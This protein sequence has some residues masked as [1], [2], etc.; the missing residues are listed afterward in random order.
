VKYPDSVLLGERS[1]PTD[2]AQSDLLAGTLHLQGV[3][4]LQAQ[5]ARS[6]SGIAT[7]PALSMIRRVFILARKR[8]LTGSSMPSYRT[9]RA[10]KKRRPFSARTNCP[11]C[12]HRS[13]LPW[14]L[15][16]LTQSQAP[17][18]VRDAP[19][20]ASWARFRQRG[21]TCDTMWSCRTRRNSSPKC[22]AIRVIGG[23]RI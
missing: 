17:P 4:G 10:V 20:E 22:V 13:G 21:T 8:G 12:G 18:G 6:G 15:E 3:A 1:R 14:K 2:R 9:L 7:R 19:S 23:L 5:I 11:I 16:Q